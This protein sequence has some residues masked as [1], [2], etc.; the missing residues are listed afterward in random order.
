MVMKNV[1]IGKG[2]TS[3]SFTKPVMKKVAD[4]KA[5]AEAGKAF[6][7]S[8]GVAPPPRMNIGKSVA[9]NAPA[10][11]AEKARKAEELTAKMRDTRGKPAT[12]PTGK[13]GRFGP[14]VMPMIPPD[15]SR[16]GPVVRPSP[17]KRPAMPA[18]PQKPFSNRTNV[19]TR[20]TTNP[21]GA[22]GEAPSDMGGGPGGVGFKKGG[23]VAKPGLYA[24]IHAKK[25]RIAAGSGEKM[26]K[27]GSK[28]APSKMDFIKSAK[29]AKR[30]R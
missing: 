1:K 16:A 5:K 2:V 11:N 13:A 29:T 10:A 8:K 12:N 14:G 4:N 9:K 21:E 15:V 7:K 6:L 25:K 26:R 27:V 17:Q 22:L 18:R 23:S 20:F 3:K 30:G 19:G 24:N 28:G